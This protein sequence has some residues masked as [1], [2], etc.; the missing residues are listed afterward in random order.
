MFKSLEF[1][2]MEIKTE[3]PRLPEDLIAK[4]LN[5]SKSKVKRLNHIYKDQAELLKESMQKLRKAELIRELPEGDYN[6]SIIAVDGGN[7]VDKN[8]GTNM[9]LAV[10]VGVEGFNSR[11][12]MG[13]GMNQYDCW[14]EIIPHEE[15]SARLCQGIMFLMELNTIAS[16]PHKIKIMD[17]THF[18]P[19]L[20][21]NS[22]LS[23]KEEYATSE[24]VK[25][26]KKFLKDKYKKTIPDIPDMISKILE[27]N[28]II[29]MPKY[30]SST[31][32]IKSDKYSHCFSK[33]ITVD[34]R[35]FFSLNLEKN[36]YTKPL[37]VG[38]SEEE[39]RKIWNDLHIRCNIE[40]ENQKLLNKQLESKLESVKTRTESNES[41]ES[42]IYFSYYKPYE[43]S[44][45]F[46]IECKKS[47]AESSRE[48]E[49]LLR[50]IKRQLCIPHIQEPFPQ[51]LA[52]M[53]AKS[54]SGG[55]YA[56]QDAVKLSPELNIDNR[57]K[58]Y[59]FNS[60]RS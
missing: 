18:T 16:S 55:L 3:Y 32:V 14:S 11:S 31:D 42:I 30:S 45:A 43:N 2:Y 59:I 50:S 46:R 51:Y 56:L 40:I 21:I 44:L 19:I 28:S 5:S 34:D 57:F 9:L 13:W 33:D 48:F 52:D 35:F 38:Q 39:R 22:L 17:G 6:E 25:C 4:I 12:S 41:Q 20:K 49:E 10:A 54:V 7:I 15:A 27:D 8:S 29:A 36:E 53:M 1:I 47:I 37:S 26:L 60:Y 58:P 23:A 24:Y